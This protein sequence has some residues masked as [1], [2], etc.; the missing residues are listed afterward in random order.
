M[1][2]VIVTAHP[3]T[4]V[5]FTQSKNADGSAKLDKNG[6]EFGFIRAEQQELSLGFAYN[7][8][9][10]KRRSALISMTLEAWAKSA[11]MIKH[12]VELPGKI[13]RQDSLTPHFTGQKALAT[14]EGKTI[15]SNGAPVYRNEFYTESANVDD[16]KLASYDQI[17]APVTANKAVKTVE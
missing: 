8:G 1:K 4:G 16:V 12:G 17:E 5:V 13:V 3:E 7:R 10:I 9:A 11:S 14:A 15:T 6:K 2:K